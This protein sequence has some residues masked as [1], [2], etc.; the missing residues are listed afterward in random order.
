MNTVVYDDKII[1]S[2]VLEDVTFPLATKQW[3]HLHFLS[4]PHQLNILCTVLGCQSTCCFESVTAFPN[5]TIFGGI[6][7]SLRL[8]GRVKGRNVSQCWL[9]SVAKMGSHVTV[10]CRHNLIKVLN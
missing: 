1:A 5:V 7:Q 2:A 3:I 6:I 4:L 10:L 9:L 8:M